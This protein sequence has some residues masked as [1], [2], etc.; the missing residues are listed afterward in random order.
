MATLPQTKLDGAAQS[1]EALK[2][3]IQKD[4]DNS[5]KLA[6]EVKHHEDNLNY[7]NAQVNIIDESIHRLQGELRECCSS[8]TGKG[9]NS[10]SVVNTGKQLNDQVIQL[11]ETAAGV[12]CEMKDRHGSMLSTLKCTKDVLGIV[13]SL[14]KVADENLSRILSEYLGLDTLLAI[15]CK[16]VDG[17]EAL[18]SYE[19]D[20][21]VDRNAGFHG[22][23]P[24]IGRTLSGRFHVYCLQN[25]RPFSGEILP[26]DPQRR[27]ALMNPKLPNGKFPRGFL[28]FAVNMIFLDPELSSFVTVDGCGLRETLFFSLFTRLQVFNTRSD[29]MNAL[30][31]ISDGAISLDGGMVKGSSLFCLG[32]RNDISIKFPITH[33]VPNP[34]GE[35]T[36]IEQKIKLLEWKKQ[37]LFSDM[38]R[39]ETLISNVKCVLKAKSDGYRKLFNDENLNKEFKKHFSRATSP[40]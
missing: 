34:F 12:M 21:T 4:E 3:L 7:L 20:G 5:Q 24:T 36:E 32:E 35:A 40:R 9:D 1:I 13:A 17:V 39:E 19:E 33:G 28:G 31:F 30:P 16:T 23:A 2:T 37:M 29:M 25:M 6:Q 8:S 10:V 18:E 22:I 26:N 27:L 38:Q 11:Y 15:V 14:G